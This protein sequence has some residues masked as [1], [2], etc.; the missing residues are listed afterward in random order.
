[1]ET[2]EFNKI[3]GAVLAVLLFTKGLAVVSGGVIGG[4]KPEKPGYDLPSASEANAAPAH[5]GGGAPAE[6]LPVMMAKADPKKGEAAMKACATCH[7]FDK[8]GAAKV[9]PPLYGVLGRAV[10]K[11]E[12][13]GYSDGL[14][15]KGGN[16]TFEA[17]N[18]F[19]ENPK[20]YAAG[21]KMSYPGLPDAMKR[22]EILSYLNTLSD[23]P[24]PMP[25]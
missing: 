9:G 16:W 25:K 11:V 15:A 5:G 4:Y 10:G 24:L 14:K 17:V 6:P 13:F 12:G 3:A 18:S 21:T 2:M 22:A 7:S 8:G 19:I 20:A 1:M 23:A